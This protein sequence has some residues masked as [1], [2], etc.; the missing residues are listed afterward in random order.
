[1]KEEKSKNENDTNSNSAS[2]D[3]N[4][5]RGTSMNIKLPP[6]I[7][8]SGLNSTF[9]PSLL[10]IGASFLGLASVG[11]SNVKANDP[12]N[13]GNNNKNNKNHNH[14][15]YRGENADGNASANTMNNLDDLLADSTLPESNLNVKGGNCNNIKQPQ[16]TPNDSTNLSMN[17]N[18]G[19]Q[20]LYISGAS[21]IKT[22]SMVMENSGVDSESASQNAAGSALLTLSNSIGAANLNTPL[23]CPDSMLNLSN[24]SS[25]GSNSS[26]NRDLNGT[27][28]DIKS[29][30]GRQRN[31][32]MLNVGSSL[33]NLAALAST[34][35]GRSPT[36]EQIDNS[37]KRPCPSMET[38]DMSKAK[39][40]V[41]TSY[42]YQTQEEADKSTG[43]WSKQEECVLL[44]LVKGMV[45]CEL[46]MIAKAAKACRIHRQ[47]RAVDKKLK[48]LIGFKNWK[49]RD[50]KNILSE[51]Y[52]VI[53]NKEFYKLSKE[54]E[55]MV[56][57][58]IRKFSSAERR[59]FEADYSE[60]APL[61]Q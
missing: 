2:E 56:E 59:V 24:S 15:Q 41:E 33:S 13:S 44:H 17:N 27:H 46:K 36:Q 47:P 18:P 52:K 58:A 37:R 34:S 12:Q 6:G 28:Q 53:Q 22:E 55:Q 57:D 21:H 11:N 38:K 9:S 20:S 4:M 35:L 10:S 40:P 32:P 23:A 16:K 48:R 43:Q 14:N 19:D 3:M 5:K 1:V 25:T 61:M 29:D 45:S 39:K 60:P 54:R 50:Q 7:E 42:Q 31:F 26:P 51:V 49:T 30:K 8:I